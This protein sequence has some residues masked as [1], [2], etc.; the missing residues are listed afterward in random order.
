MLL[1]LVLCA[2]GGTSDQLEQAL[3]FRTDLTAAGGCSFCGEITVDY[4]DSVGRFTVECE[5]VA[6]GTVYLTVVEPEELREVTAT[7]AQQGGRVTY[8]GLSVEFGLLAEGNLI[9]AAAPA[10]VADCW[11]EA[12]ISS[13]GTEGEDYRVTYERDYGEKRLTVDTFFKNGLPYLAQVCYNQSC[14]L[15]LCIS[16]F[17]MN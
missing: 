12:Y 16:D 2:C 3:R 1:A 4:G 10:V 14:V 17:K 6:D 15:Q 7:V 9:P 11:S 5:V 8:D 13:A